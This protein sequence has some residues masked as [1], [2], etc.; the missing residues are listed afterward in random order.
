[1]Q[2]GKFIF[3]IKFYPFSFKDV[4][5]I[6]CLTFQV[7]LCNGTTFSLVILLK[8]VASCPNNRQLF[9]L[10]CH[11][12]FLMEKK[13]QCNAPQQPHSAFNLYIFPPSLLTS[14]PKKIINKEC[15]Q[16]KIKIVKIDSVP[17]VWLVFSQ[18]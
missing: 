1:M 2:K 14:P 12:H 4:T 8:V 10:T 15:L 7:S 11:Y 18:R 17:L 3:C 16:T 13:Y 5:V 6:A 9:S